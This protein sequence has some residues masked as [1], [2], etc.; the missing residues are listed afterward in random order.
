VPDASLGERLL[1]IEGLALLRLVT[2]ADPDMRRA[3]VEE[4]RALLASIDR[5]PDLAALGGTAYDV[6]EGYRVWSQT[7]DAPLRLF[8]IEERSMHALFD[9]LPPSR[10]VLDAA[11]GTGRHSRVLAERGH[12]VIGVDL[13][14]EMLAKARQHVPCGEFHE[15]RFDA[16]PLPDASVDAVVCALALVHV[17]DLAPATREFSRVL[18]P[19]GRVIVSDVHPFPILLGWQAQFRTADGAL[20]FIRLNPHLPSDYSR[21]FASAGLR[22]RGCD[23]ALLPTEAAATAGAGRMPD[24]AGIAYGGLP[25][26]IVWD[27]EKSG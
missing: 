20:G 4:M 21:A 18:R 3:R 13:S 2:G 10:T 9:T 11:C 15:G 8:P 5:E 27:L 1:G 22:I 26:V 12:R 23:E 17:S 6:A 25:G 16:L 19:G 24:A 14:A 7:Y